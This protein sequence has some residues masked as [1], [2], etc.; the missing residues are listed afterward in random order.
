M[1]ELNPAAWLQNA[2]ATH[3]ANVMR[4]FQLLLNGGAEG[5]LRTSGVGT[6]AVSQRGAGANMSVDVA[7]GIACVMGD[8]SSM[9]G[10]YGIANDATKNV[11]IAAS[12]PTNPRYDLIVCRVR[13]SFYSG[14]TNAWDL[15]VV[16]GTPAASPVDPTVP[17]NA[18]TLARVTVNA[19][20]SSITNAN[21]TDL[22][23]YVPLGILP[24]NSA[25]RPGTL[26]GPYSQEPSFKS[27]LTSG[28]PVV[29]TDTGRVL[30][31]DGSAFQRVAAYASTGRT[32]VRLRRA[33]T[34]TLTNDTYTT[35]SWDTEDQDTDAFI[36][37]PSTTVTIPSG[38]GG[39]YLAAAT[40]TVPA[41]SY[42]NLA[43]QMTK[44][45]ALLATWPWFGIAV[46]TAATEP[47]VTATWTGQLA[48]GDTL[49][50]KVF[51]SSGA[52]R[53]AT[54]SLELVRL[55]A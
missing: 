25:R 15:F 9:Q 31:H 11:T 32:A 48:A 13:D 12:D 44:N 30:I 28:V 46:M 38:L 55:S 36:A 45:G 6:F 51:Q 53:A 33:A 37:V 4:L 35:I 22:R 14:S 20:A 23:P 1:A 7:A 10:L 26:Y 43:I 19:G 52:N 50:W 41:A 2:G 27:V 42:T 8:E 39:I 16:Q 49:T 29:E 18:I 17:S 21:I 47:L 34:Q 54:G 24:V 5:V 40:I 3:N